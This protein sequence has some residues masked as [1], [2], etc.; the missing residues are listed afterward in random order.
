MK[1]TQ[2]STNRGFDGITLSGPSVDILFSPDLSNKNL[3]TGP[4]IIVAVM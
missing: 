1:G 3:S 2:D 4:E